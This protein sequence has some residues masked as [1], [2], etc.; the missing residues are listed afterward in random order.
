ML[1]LN[2]YENWFREKEQYY[3]RSDQEKLDSNVS[4]HIIQF[5]GWAIIFIF[6]DYLIMG[7]T[8]SA[9]KILFLFCSIWWIL[10]DGG[11]NLLRHLPFFRVSKVSGNPI[12]KY[13]TPVIK[14]I[15]LT[16]AAV[17]YIW[18]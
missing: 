14:I 2:V 18:A 16:L 1:L 10:F 5:F 17:V 4:W 6:N 3:T 13:G 8:F 9:F 12:E 7:I 15:L 11:L